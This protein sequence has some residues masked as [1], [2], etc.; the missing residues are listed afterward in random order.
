MLKYPDV[1]VLQSL[2]HSFLPHR[3][4]SQPNTQ[5]NTL[6]WYALYLFTLFLEIKKV[7]KTL[8]CIKTHAYSLLHKHSHL[9]FPTG[10]FLTFK[11]SPLHTYTHT[12]MH[13]HIL[14]FTQTYSYEHSLTSKT[15]YFTPP[16]PPT[17][18]NVLHILLVMSTRVNPNF[19]KSFFH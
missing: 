11:H 1:N 9:Q 13:T 7:L 10:N 8:V 14:H 16:P 5:P 6:K 15:K 2:F 17:H 12:H 18:T 3:M 4:W 19:P